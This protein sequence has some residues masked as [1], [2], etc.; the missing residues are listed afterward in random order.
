L[1][2]IEDSGEADRA[3][4][5]QRSEPPLTASEKDMLCGWMDFH[6]ATMLRKIDGLSEDA[7]RRPMV[8][9]GTSLLGMVKHLAFAEDYWFGQIFAGGDE[10]VSRVEPGVPVPDD[11]TT[12][13]V[14]SLYEAMCERSRA[15]VDAA[16]LHDRARGTAGNRRGPASGFNLRWILTHMIEETARHNGHADILREQIDGTTGH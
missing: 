14:V 15:V 7:V 12:A 13:D 8:A 6:R 4:T 5:P 11:E 9:S 16:D 3:V 10:V 2:A 1:R